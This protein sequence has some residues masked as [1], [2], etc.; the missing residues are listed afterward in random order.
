MYQHQLDPRSEDKQPLKLRLSPERASSADQERLTEAVPEGPGQHLLALQSRYGNRH[1]QRVVN[2]ARGA[3]AAQPIHAKPVQRK[4][5][6][7]ETTYEEGHLADL[8]LMLK[9]PRGATYIRI[10]KKWLEQEDT[11]VFETLEELKSTLENRS[12]KGKEIN[13]KGKAREGSAAA[14]IGGTVADA[15]R[16]G[17]DEIVYL[18]ESPERTNH[19]HVKL[20]IKSE[21]VYGIVGGAAKANNLEK[22]KT[23]CR[24]LKAISETH[25]KRPVVFYEN[26]TPHVV[27]EAAVEIVGEA[28][29]IERKEETGGS[30]D[31]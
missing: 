30:D 7:G 23:I 31:E 4:V 16:Y 28:N 12:K 25:H 27:V 9:P 19:R 15:G 3:G 17:Q 8:L 1:V 26:D 2:A 5:K 29:V 20:D 22:F 13:E 24:D 14:S 10:L 18:D 6:I 21:T 11:H